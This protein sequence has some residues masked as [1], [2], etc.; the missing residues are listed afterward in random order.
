[1]KPFRDGAVKNPQDAERFLE[2]I[3]KH[4]DRLRGHHRGSAEPFQNR[5]DF[6]EKEGLNIVESR[7]DMTSSRMPFRSVMWPSPDREIEVEVSCNDSLSLKGRP[8]VAGTGPGQSSGQRRQVQRYDGGT[9]Q[10]A[11]TEEIRMTSPV[12]VQDHGVGINKK[13]LPRLFER[14]Y[15]VDKARSRQLGGTGLGLAI[16]KHVVQAHGGHISVESTPGEG[17]AFSIHLPGNQ[18]GSNR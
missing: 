5:T 14:F 17:S 18:N 13:H 10:I 11:V 15:R 8:H 6:A 12:A 1:M 2:I 3:E 7:N 16:V 4:V 9:V